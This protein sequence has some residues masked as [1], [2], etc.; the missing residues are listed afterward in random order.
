MKKIIIGLVG[1]PSSG[2]D[3]VA[4]YLITK[5]F[6]HHSTSDVV[7]DYIAKNNLGEPVRE[8]MQETANMLRHK[9][10]PDCLV[11]E[12][13]RNSPDKFVTSGMRNPAEVT[14]LKKNGAY[15]IEVAASI[16]VRYQRAKVRGRVGENISLEKFVDIEQKEAKNSDPEA[17]NTAAVIALADRKI[18]NNGDLSS[19]YRQVDMVL[20]SLEPT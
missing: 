10:G 15:I 5:G 2:K 7:R 9:N 11:K 14:Y 6:A 17:Q 16:E 18:E 1:Q 8:L 13:L 4:A 3:T 12:A 19:L 20:E